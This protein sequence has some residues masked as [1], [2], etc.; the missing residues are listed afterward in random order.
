MEEVK[1]S[2]ASLF[3]TPHD[4]SLLELS[5]GKAEVGR[6]GDCFVASATQA[7]RADTKQLNVP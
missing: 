6:A 5:Y 7:K 4:N 2:L 3:Y 1:V